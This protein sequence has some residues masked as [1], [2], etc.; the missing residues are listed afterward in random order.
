MTLS[1]FLVLLAA[2]NVF[3]N[4]FC[5]KEIR[6]LFII[7]NT[8]TCATHRGA[9]AFYTHVHFL[10]FIKSPVDY[11]VILIRP[12]HGGHVHL[13]KKIRFYS[14]CRKAQIFQILSKTPSALTLFFSLCITPIK[15]TLMGY[16]WASMMNLQSQSVLNSPGV[17]YYGS[18][19]ASHCC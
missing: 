19:S 7:S 1:D 2:G 5:H 13:E 16:R 17:S 18:L 10:E 4:C 6:Q 8:C 11:N 3:F 12:Q 15:R 14:H 9:T